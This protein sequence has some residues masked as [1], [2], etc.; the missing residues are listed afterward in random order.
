MK[1][2]RCRFYINSGNQSL[3]NASN[4]ITDAP[5]ILSPR[6]NLLRSAGLVFKTCM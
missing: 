5:K 6:L 2:E 1:A 4:A 3:M